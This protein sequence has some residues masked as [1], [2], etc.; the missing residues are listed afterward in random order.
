MNNFWIKF[1]LV[2][3][4]IF[5]TNNIYAS[6]LISNEE[7]RVQVLSMIESL[8]PTL[9]QQVDK[10][11]TWF[12]MKPFGVR[13]LEYFYKVNMTKEQIS[14]IP[15]VQTALN[16]MQVKQYCTTS[17]LEGFRDEFVEMKWSYIDKNNENIFSLR[18]NPND[19]K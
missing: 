2:M 1:L 6:K 5:I 7:V 12:D 8:K 17:G 4:C 19:C 13:G 16:N 15:N 10:N 11:T 18:A 9:P 3:L 14:K